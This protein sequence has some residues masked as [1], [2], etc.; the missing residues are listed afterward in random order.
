MPITILDPRAAPSIAITPYTLACDPSGAGLRV[1][2]VSNCF[3]DA[4]NLLTA[5]GE[6][7]G[8][9]L[10]APVITLYEFPN[11]S[12]LAPPEDIARIAASND[13]A[14]TRILK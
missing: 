13:G 5:V 12:L 9:L 11:A 6:A 14:I 4:S 10:D 3:F 8:G 7:L 2:L 1:A